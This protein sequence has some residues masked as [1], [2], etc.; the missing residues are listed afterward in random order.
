MSKRN[1]KDEVCLT[2]RLPKQVAVAL[3][4]R[5]KAFSRSIN[6]QILHEIGYAEKITKIGAE[7][8]TDPNA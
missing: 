4:K 5:A 6:G 8:L 7:A 3:R 2:L 1:K